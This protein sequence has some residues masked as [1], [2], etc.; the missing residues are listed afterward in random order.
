MYP[1][2][3]MKYV[4]VKMASDHKVQPGVLKLPP[5]VG[6]GEGLNHKDSLLAFDHTRLEKIKMM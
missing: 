6:S 3:I 4:S 1:R 5:C 2:S